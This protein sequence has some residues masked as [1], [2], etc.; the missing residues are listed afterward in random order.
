MHSMPDAS[1]YPA[2]FQP[3]PPPPGG[4]QLLGK[5]FTVPAGTE[6]LKCVYLDGTLPA[7]MDLKSV[8]GYQ[9]S[10]GHH[11]LFSSVVDTYHPAD[12]V[13]DCTDVEMIYSRTIAG[14]GTQSAVVLPD[15][16]AMKV[17]AGKRFVIQ[18]HY[19]NATDHD[20][21]AMDAVN[22]IP[23]AQPVAT[24]VSMA[25]ANDD[26]FTL[27]A[28]QQTTVD[29][30]CNV[31]FDMQLYNLI[32]HTHEYGK[33]F[34]FTVEHAGGSMETLYDN[35]DVSPSFR[36]NAV[37]VTW[38]PNAPEQLVAGDKLHMHC[39]WDNTTNHDITFPQEM[40]AAAFYYAPSHG[41]LICDNG[42]DFFTQGN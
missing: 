13:H 32:G 37:Q 10:G 38:P 9:T 25:A 41:F 12:D 24:Y 21:V 30:T 11:I 28:M 8:Q 33:K 35:P 34:S 39:E 42:G 17:Q 6:V 5:P 40:C 2:D 16:L 7:D 36:D 19:I 20:I 23:A 31:A 4:A 22:L 26:T 1:P 3:P 18:S 15:G 27:P 14:T 29:T